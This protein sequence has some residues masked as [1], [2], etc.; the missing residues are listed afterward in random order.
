[1]NRYLGLFFFTLFV[2]IVM[3]FL[4]KFIDNPAIYYAPVRFDF[5][6]IIFLFFYALETAG[7]STRTKIIY[8]IPA[9]IEFLALSVLF[10]AILVNPQFYEILEDYAFLQFF[11]VISSIYIVSICVLIIRIALRHQ[12]SLFIH[13]QNT[14][15]KSLKWLV[16]FCFLCIFLNVIRNLVSIYPDSVYLP[17][18]FCTTA[19]FSLYYITIGSLIQINIDNVISSQP[20]VNESKEELEEVLN[21]IEAYLVKNK[22]Y[23][24]P[25]MNL[26]TFSRKINLPE[27]TISKAINKIEK[28]N[29]TSYINAYRI[30]EFK[31]RLT[32]KEYKKYSISAIADEVGFNSRASFY[33]NFKDI[34][35][36]SPLDYIKKYK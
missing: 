17:V 12:K 16:I 24:N 21:N 3:Y 26:K 19:L 11:R 23:L 10:I 36:L 15:F 29:F 25:E 34:V 30:E 33:K 27:R 9:V 31:N 32:N 22:L 20:E 35:G 7:I 8:Y 18:I 6:S 2:E 1:M 5:L 4:F 14:K 28:K 13:F